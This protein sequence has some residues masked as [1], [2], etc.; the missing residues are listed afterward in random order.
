LNLHPDL[1]VGQIRQERELT[2]CQA[3]LS[4]PPQKAA[5]REFRPRRS[6]SARNRRNRSRRSRR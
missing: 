6:R 5:I 4:C 1:V 2:L 3:H